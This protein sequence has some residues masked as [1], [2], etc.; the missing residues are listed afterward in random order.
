MTRQPPRRSLGELRT[1]ALFHLSRRFNRALV[2]P[3]WLSINLTLRCNLACSF[4]H[5]C[6]DMED[7][8]TT[9]EVRSVIDQAADW[10]VP[11]FNPLG[12]EPMLRRDLAEI[13]WFADRRGFHVSLTTNGTL[14]RGRRIRELA[15][16]PKLAI[17]VSIDGLQASHDRIR[18]EGTFA[19]I[20]ENLRA[21]RKVE[22][23]EGLPRTHLG[24]N[25]VIHAQNLDQLIG[26]IETAKRLDLDR[27]QFLFLTIHE[28]RTDGIQD[29]IV[30]EDD[31]PRLDRAI[32]ELADYVAGDRSGFCYTNTVE[33][34]LLAKDFY[35]GRLAPEKAVCFNG[36]KELYI[37]ADGSV[38]MCDGHL[39]F[40]AEVAGNVREQTLQEIWTGPRARRMRQ[41]VLDCQRGCLQ[42]CYLRRDSERLRTIV[43]DAA[44]AGW[45]RTRKAAERS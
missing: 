43:W 26:V 13:L 20:L 41:K 39:N 44:R 16:I 21:Y 42:D 11:V 14:L 7:E 30:G 2:R 4:C 27:V 29:L 35:R 6:Y 12:G 24:I 23:D 38:L 19:R 8:L 28:G 15:P 18:G 9:D 36:W 31:L 33:D 37:N 5:T 34:L 1:D 17:N 25:C 40:L 3:D 32:E 45:H 22:N 10:G